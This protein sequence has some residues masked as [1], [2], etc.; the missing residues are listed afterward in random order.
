MQLCSLVASFI[1]WFL[2]SRRS[3][4]G[5]WLARVNQHRGYLMPRR[6]GCLMPQRRFFLY[7]GVKVNTFIRRRRRCFMPRH[8]GYTLCLT[9]EATLAP[10]PRLFYATAPRLYFM[11]HHRGY[12]SPG[13]EVVL[14]HGTEAILYAYST[15]FI[16]MVTIKIRVDIFIIARNNNLKCP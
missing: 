3:H 9:A 4:E 6:G 14:C 11:P 2:H 5:A 15:S 16:T 1:H 12:F 10:V 13:A 7:L 8:R